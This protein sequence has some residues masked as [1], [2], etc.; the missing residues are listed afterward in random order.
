MGI[1]LC[2]DA[3]HNRRL[4]RLTPRNDEKRLPR[5]TPRNDEKRKQQITNN[6]KQTTMKKLFISM[7]AVAALASCS[8]EQT[9]SFDKGE[10]IG[11]GAFVENST[12][13]AADPSY[14]AKDIESFKVYGT[15]T[16][17]LIYDGVTVSRPS[18]VKGEGYNEEWKCAGNQQYWIADANY[19]FVGIVD[20]DK[21]GVT[22]TN[23]DKGM[24]TSVEYTADGKT[25]LLCQTIT[26][27]N[28]TSIVAFNFTHLLSKV[29]FTVI[30]N[31]IDAKDYIFVAR[32]I[33]FDGAK[34]GTYTI[35]YPTTENGQL[36]AGD[37]AITETDDTDLSPLTVNATDA[38]AELDTE[39][40][41]I[42]GS[43]AVD[44]AVDVY[45]KSV[46]PENKVTTMDY[47]GS[48]Q[49][50]DANKAYNFVVN[51]SLGDPIQFTVTEKPTWEDGDTADDTTLTL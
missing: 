3:E 37:W 48:D 17:V 34:K 26:R 31:S 35:A 10:E 43:Y 41:F 16:D 9:V 46:A 11:F 28:D 21:D 5:L 36:V 20:G 1:Y 23:F 2:E 38:S 4:P 13:A 7:L 42:P 32:D 18:D 51:V 14:S 39:V 8:K 40:L 45:Y 6:L 19:K 22:K 50:L 44:F 25:D 47:V 15:V 30:N 12:R 27:K 29:N 33:T 24:P 49:S